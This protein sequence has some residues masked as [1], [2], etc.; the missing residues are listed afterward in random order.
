MPSLCRLPYTDGM[1]YIHGVNRDHAREIAKREKLTHREWRYVQDTGDFRGTP[2]PTED[3][4]WTPNVIGANL[5]VWNAQ[6]R[7]CAM[8][9]SLG[10]TIRAV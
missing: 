6:Y 8:A 3:V 9:K 5:E 1:I 10:V 4:L 2:L 7:L